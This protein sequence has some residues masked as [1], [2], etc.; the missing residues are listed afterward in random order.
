MKLKENI[1]TFCRFKK[2]F[3]NYLD[4]KKLTN[5]LGYEIEY[6]YQKKHFYLFFIHLRYILRSLFLHFYIFFKTQNI[7]KIFK[8][9]YIYV[10]LHYY[11]EAYIY[12]QVNFDELNMVNKI[13]K[14]TPNDFL[15][16]N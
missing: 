9:K 10:P 7:K 2:I 6:Y 1:Y 14:N 5:K 8:S 3:L 16:S 11:P 4:Y 12:N 13:L 15:F